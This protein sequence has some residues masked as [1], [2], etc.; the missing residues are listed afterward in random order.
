[1]Q[2][3]LMRD[4]WEN[5]DATQVW[6]SHVHL[7]GTSD[8]GSATWYNPTMSSL[9]HPQ[10]YIQKLFYMNAACIN[11]AP[12]KMDSSYIERILTQIRDM[13]PG[14]K[15]ML[16]A[17]DL[18]HDENGRE[19]RN[20]SI[21]YVPNRYA[22]RVAH[23]HPDAFEWVAS[24]HPYRAD[25]VEELHKA[26]EAGALAVKWL[27]SAMGIDPASR[28]CDRFYE[29]LARTRIPLISHA[30][31]EKAVQGGDQSFGNPLR[32]RR[33]LDHGVRV[34][35]AHCASD[36]EDQ[37][38][39]R[40]ENGAIVSSFSLFARL[41][42]EARYRDN[43]YA[44]ISALTQLNRIWTLKTVLQRSDWHSRLL[45]GS[46][47]PLPGIMPLFSVSAMKH[48]LNP[49]AVPFLQ[50]IH[51]YNP[52]LFDFASKRLLHDGQHCFA[53]GVFETRRF[54]ERSVT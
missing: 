21:F 39:D 29:A 28:H 12:G 51:R 37:D 47:Y 3:P 14:F 30:G 46:D 41:M 20:R 24:I 5:I 42:D 43:L 16:Y 32:L 38:I 44:D 31:R 9:W 15:T 49:E 13:K 33:A 26:D 23:A 6:D 19:D 4:V 11:E 45:N 52:L 25:C 2:H 7:I 10:L 54:F 36:G 17:F 22:A 53:P 48:M 1:M 18:F 8:T 40:G 35:M 50:E 34:V 27:P